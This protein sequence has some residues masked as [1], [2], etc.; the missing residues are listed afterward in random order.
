M[1]HAR[2]DFVI[3]GLRAAYAYPFE[4][5]ELLPGHIDGVYLYGKSLR[6]RELMVHF[7]E[8]N[9]KTV[10]KGRRLGTI[11][12]LVIVEGPIRGE[13]MSVS[14]GETIRDRINIIESQFSDNLV[15]PARPRV[16][17]VF[18]SLQ[19]RPGHG[20]PSVSGAEFL[21]AA[22]SQ[23]NAQLIIPDWEPDLALIDSQH[24]RLEAVEYYHQNYEAELV[25]REPMLHEEALSILRRQFNEIPTTVSLLTQN[26]IRCGANN[27]G[28]L[29]LWLRGRQF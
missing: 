11:D 8:N 27:T 24:D 26:N 3:E 22:A 2:A 21:G 6:N 15:E 17:R 4:S 20:P 28:L 9:N 19:V 10:L 16:N 1:N 13:Y 5:F 7:A 18:F 23:M 14:D 29:A 25:L 12:G